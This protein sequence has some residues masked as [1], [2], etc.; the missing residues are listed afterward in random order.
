MEFGKIALEFNRRVAL[1]ELVSH[2]FIDGHPR[3]R[4]STFSDGTVTECDFDAETFS[5]TYPDG[6]TVTG[7]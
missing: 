4:R 1:C 5:I 3:R 6:R 7:N 2:E